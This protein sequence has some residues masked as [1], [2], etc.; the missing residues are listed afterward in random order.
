MSP[1]HK[2]LAS[3]RKQNKY[4]AYTL[5]VIIENIIPSKLIAQNAHI[6]IKYMQSN[7]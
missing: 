2:F 6:S 1:L 5:Y 7:F 3:K 4:L